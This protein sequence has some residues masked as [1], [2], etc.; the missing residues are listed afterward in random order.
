MLADITVNG[1][2]GSDK[3]ESNMT[4]FLCKDGSKWQILSISNYGYDFED[5]YDSF[6]F[7]G[8]MNMF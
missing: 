3:Y 1:K 5:Y 6:N 8:L 7:N 4:L 2:S